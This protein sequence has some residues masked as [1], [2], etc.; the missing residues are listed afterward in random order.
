MRE[1]ARSARL[2][3]EINWKPRPGWERSSDTGTGKWGKRHGSSESY[4]RYQCTR[5]YLISK[6]LS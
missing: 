4:P 1:M 2:D 6:F 3:A 5:K